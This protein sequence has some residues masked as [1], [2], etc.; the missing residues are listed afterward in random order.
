ML[1][2]KEAEGF[3]DKPGKQHSRGRGG[4]AVNE[5]CALYEILP[6]GCSRE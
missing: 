1:K 2:Y 3:D 4:E 5:K 6:P